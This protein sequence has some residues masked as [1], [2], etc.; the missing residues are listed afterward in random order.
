MPYQVTER[1]L[2]GLHPGRPLAITLTRRAL[3]LRVRSRQ[4]RAICQR[5]TPSQHSQASGDAE[6][7]AAE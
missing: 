4:R 5:R 2:L 7:A 1:L 3:L 6:T